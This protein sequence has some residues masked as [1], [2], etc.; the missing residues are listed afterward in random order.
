MTVEIETVEMPISE[1]KELEDNPRTIKKQ[2][3]ENLKK[4]IKDFPE[5]R[6]MREIVVDEDYTVLGGNQRLRAMRELGIEKAPV[7]IVKGLSDYKKREFIIKDNISNGEFDMDI[8]ANQ[9]DA[10]ELLDW[11]MF[12]VKHG[13]K[14]EKDL[15]K[16]PPAI[17]ASFLTFDDDEEIRLEITDDTALKLMEQ[18][19]E[20]REK[21]GSYEG[22]WD[23][24]FEEQ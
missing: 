14:D 5:M 8:L 22:F 13:I 15:E 21:K 17:V 3:F 19:L 20:Y 12:D 10:D 16:E 24:H 18:M 4:S 1:L 11:G 2:D 6:E 23:E 7:K 9:W